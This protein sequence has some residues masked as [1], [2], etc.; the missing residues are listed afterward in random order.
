MAGLPGAMAAAPARRNGRVTL[1]P[2]HIRMQICGGGGGAGGV[3]VGWV[4]L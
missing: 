4:E 2:A 3:E 1:L